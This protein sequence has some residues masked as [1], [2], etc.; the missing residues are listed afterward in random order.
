MDIG[1][2]IDIDKQLLLTVNGSDNLFTDS[3]AM[4]LTAAVTWIPLYIALLYVV[5]R[6]NE[7]L[8]KVFII[9][10][11][12][13]LCVLLTGTLND[14]LVKPYVARLRPTHDLDIGTLTD[15]VNG[16]RGGR[17]GFFSSHAAN[18]FS[19]AVFLSL[20]VRNKVLTFALILWSLINCWTRMYL[21][22]HFP[23]DIIAGLLWG[24]IIGSIV[25]VLYS[26]VNS[27]TGMRFISS[28]YTSTGYLYSDVDIVVSV[29]GYTIIYALI[30][31]CVV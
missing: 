9:L 17:Y 29:L 23:G 16:Y 15:V 6:N 10:L 20:V 7:N 14:V 3:L 25:Y 30:R 8:R 5:I 2:L 24:G 11:S 19:V 4:T 18:T 26:H 12:V 27:H 21:G 13:G 22:V 31:A 28:Q 1:N